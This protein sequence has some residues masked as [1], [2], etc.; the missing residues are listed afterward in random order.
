MENFE[1]VIYGKKV[2]LGMVEDLSI[3]HQ[4][5]KIKFMIASAPSVSF[6]WPNNDDSCWIHIHQVLSSV[7]ITT[8]TT[9]RM[10]TISKKIAKSVSP[11]QE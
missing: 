3:E 1:P 4:D 8:A 6:W 5:V 9:G 11:I 7:D 10:Y 2:Y